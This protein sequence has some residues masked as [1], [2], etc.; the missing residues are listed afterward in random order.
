MGRKI[1]LGGSSIKAYC[2]KIYFQFFSIISILR[3][4]PGPSGLEFVELMFLFRNNSLRALEET[5]KRFKD[6][7]YYP[8]PINTVIIYDPKIVKELLLKRGRFVKGFQTDKLKKVMGEGLVTNNDFKSWEVSRDIV[9]RELNAKAIKGFSKLMHELSRKHT[10]SWSRLIEND[11]DTSNFSVF[12][13]KLSFDIAGHAL[14]GSDLTEE[15]AEEVDAAVEYCAYMAHLHMF[16]FLPIPYWIPTKANRVFHRHN[17][18]LSRIV[19]RLINSE[20]ARVSKSDTPSILQ[21]MATLPDHI[22]SKKMLKDEIITMIIAGYETTANS[23]CWILGLLAKH[24]E[25]QQRIRDELNS[26][27]DIIESISFRKSHPELYRAIL[28]GIRLYTTV[29]MSSRRNLFIENI[30]GYKIPKNTSIVIP[31]WNIHRDER[32]WDSPLDYR[33]ERFIDLDSKTLDHFVP[34]S[35]G[36]RSCVG[37]NFSMVEMAIM[38]SHTIKHY[39]LSLTGTDLPEA[40]SQVSLRP[41]DGM[42]LKA[43]LV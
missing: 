29:P 11:E 30:G 38:V 1:N 16:S 27:P 12:I 14:L 22:L 7:A 32:Y 4:I 6:I 20:Q 24:S 40:V 37:M 10:H 5:Q 26:N 41:K 9:T 34:F 39:K 33:P 42:W 28:E 35:K 15:D 18:N 43:E 13:Q 36:E 2:Y 23:V 17:K 21:R 8:W 25:V 3:K 19:Y 31:A